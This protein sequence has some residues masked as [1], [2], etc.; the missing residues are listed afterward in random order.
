[1]FDLGNK[2]RLTRLAKQ[3]N[4]LHLGCGGFAAKTWL[5][6]DGSWHVLLADKPRLKK[7]AAISRLLPG[8]HTAHPWAPEIIRLDLR[9]DLPFPDNSFVAVYSS[10]VLEHLQRDQALALL[11]SIYGCCRPGGVVRMAVPDLAKYVTDYQMGIIS[12]KAPGQSAADTLLHR[13]FLRPPLAQTSLIPKLYHTLLDF[14]SHKW[15]YDRD[16]LLGLFNEAG[17]PQARECNILKGQMT[18]LAQIERPER[19]GGGSTLIIEA[20]KGM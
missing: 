6:T 10:H 7:L 1:M 13:L 16:S 4:K 14:N 5:N 12:P 17:F 18:G 15:L 2:S 19:L 8:I 20:T 11:R 3:H 9:R